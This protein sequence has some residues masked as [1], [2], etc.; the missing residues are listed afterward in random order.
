M[1]PEKLMTFPVG[2]RTALENHRACAS[3]PV[4]VELNASSC[5]VST[6]LISLAVVGRYLP[7]VVPSTP[8]AERN[9]AFV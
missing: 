9:C 1:A 7:G 5:A 8:P 6:V 2:S 3:G 4:A